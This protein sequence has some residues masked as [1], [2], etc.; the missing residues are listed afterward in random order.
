MKQFIVMVEENGR[1][2]AFPFHFLLLLEERIETSDRIAF[3]TS[4]RSASVQDEYEFS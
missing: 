2:V 3:K 4:H 1:Q